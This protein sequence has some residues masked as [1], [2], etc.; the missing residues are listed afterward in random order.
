MSNFGVNG[1][2][3]TTTMP[4]A[5]PAA[6][7]A[8]PPPG[9]PYTGGAATNVTVPPAWPTPVNV[10]V[11]TAPAYGNNQGYDTYI[12]TAVSAAPYGAGIAPGKAAVSKIREAKEFFLKAKKS[13]SAATAARAGDAGRS[14]MFGSV[15]GAIKSSVIVNGILSLAV[16]GYKVYT[17][18]STLGQAG[19]EFTGDMMSAVV[20]G[21]AGGVAS[22]VGTF[23][24]AGILG[25]GLP[26][27]LAGIG[28]GIAGYMLA[29][30]V[31][32]KTSFYQNAKAKVAQMLA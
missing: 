19:G 28:L 17:K 22:A 16:N 20:G 13:K 21:A 11:N 15:M 31:L 24:L 14:A 29:D 10:P 27:T 26:L 32:K 8:P 23:A 18:Q 1:Y 6:P 5:P 30:S 3:A 25:T 7:P 4:P 12:Q 9:M 2:Y